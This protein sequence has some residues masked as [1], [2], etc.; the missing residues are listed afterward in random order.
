MWHEIRNG[1][2]WTL[3]CATREPRFWATFLNNP[4]LTVMQEFSEMNANY[5]ARMAKRPVER[6]LRSLPFFVFGIGLLQEA[7]R[8]YVNPPMRAY[9]ELDDDHQPHMLEH[10]NQAIEA[11]TKSPDG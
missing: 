5:A 4:I 11:R 3:A 10:V 7:L 1:E 2:G 9:A 8:G 6:F